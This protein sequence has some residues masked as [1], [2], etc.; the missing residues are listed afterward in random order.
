MGVKQ[1]CAKKREEGVAILMVLS[2]VTILSFVLAEFTF[3]SKV[4]RL[5][6]H[7]EGDQAMARLSAEAGVKFA[8]SKLRIYQ[9][10][11]NALGKEGGGLGGMVSPA[12][13]EQV[14]TQPLVLPVP[15]DEGSMS[16]IQKQ[17]ITEFNETILLPGTL[18][19]SIKSV[20]AFLNPN[21]L[22]VAP[23]EEGNPEARDD[24]NE[25]QDDENPDSEPRHQQAQEEFTKMITEFLSRERE[26][27]VNYDALYG[28]LEAERLV[29]ELSFY[30]NAP[31]RYTDPMAQD[32]AS[33]YAEDNVVPKHGP[34]TSLDE[35]YL[36]RGWNDAIID[37]VKNQL[38]VHSADIISLN[39]ITN[40]Q[41]QAIFPGIT[42]GQIEDFF[43]RRDGNEELGIPSTAFTSLQDFK[44][45]VVNDLGI[46]AEETF[47][48]RMATLE[49]VGVKPDTAGKLFEVSSTG[50]V[51]RARYT[52]EAIIDLPLAPTEA[53]PRE[54]EEPSSAPSPEGNTP[55]DTPTQT[56]E[57][58]EEEEG[59]AE[60]K[61]D[62]FLAPRIVEIKVL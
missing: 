7:N 15:I 48:E 18:I 9:E 29:G 13:I 22:I 28:T 30:V 3:D 24:D 41:L 58:R 54:G 44:N 40:T 56:E 62:T 16:E 19:V 4:N 6:V 26:T 49:G 8:L 46:V 52:I 20:S 21:S 5:R 14:I 59:E 31:G 61:K 37:L 34:L 57:E 43:N 36:L 33:L 35:L 2:A 51:G 53:P 47:D 23:P 12:N 1:V 50:E 25:N 32:F 42:D 39:N 55:T 45:L 27:N 38:T 10:A 17:T 60:E 11:R